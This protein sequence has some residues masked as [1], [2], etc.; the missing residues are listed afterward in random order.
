MFETLIINPILNNKVSITFLI[1][2]VK[3]NLIT[4]LE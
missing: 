3:L 4:L 1:N 2:L